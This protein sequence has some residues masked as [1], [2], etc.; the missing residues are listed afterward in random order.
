MLIQFHANGSRP[1]GWPRDPAGHEPQAP[2]LRADPEQGLGHR[3]GQ[4]LGIRQARRVPDPGRAAS[5]S[6][7]LTYSAVRRVL[8]SVVTH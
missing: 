6:S 5:Q 7:I 2:R 8:I 3:Q 1:T 4:Q